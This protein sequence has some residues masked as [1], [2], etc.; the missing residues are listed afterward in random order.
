[1]SGSGPPEEERL[2]DEGFLSRWSRRKQAQA[3]QDAAIAP[4]SPTEDERQPPALTDEDM[5]PLETLDENSDFSAFMSPEVSDGLR[6]LALRKLFHGAGFTARDGLDDYDDDFTSFVKLGDLITSDMKFRMRQVVEAEEG[7]ATE[8][9]SE[10]GSP[11]NQDAAGQQPVETAMLTDGAAA[12]V[13][14]AAPRAEY[15]DAYPRLEK[16]DG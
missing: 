8:Q 12:E 2:A 10:Q 11:G 16:K 3:G 14:E 5:P 6:N 9:T 15:L 13:R 7:Q 4:L 1:M